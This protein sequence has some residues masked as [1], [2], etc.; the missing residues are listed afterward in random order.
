[1]PQDVD[2]LQINYGPVKIGGKIYFCPVR[3][4]SLARGRSIVSLKAWD[5]S[6][7]SYGPYSTKMNDMRFSDY[8]VFRS[9]LHILPGFNPKK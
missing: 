7:L 2:E 6:F 3:S 8:H 9:E 1:M 4:V 5:E